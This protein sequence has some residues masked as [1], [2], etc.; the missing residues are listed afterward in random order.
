MNKRKTDPIDGTL[1]GVAEVSAMTGFT[2]HQI[3]SWR[4]PEN[5]DKAIFEAL[6]DPNSSTVWYRLV[7]VEDWREAH[8]KQSFMRAIPAPNAFKSTR[9]GT[10][11]EDYDKRIALE[12][13]ANITTSTVMAWREKLASQDSTLVRTYLKQYAEPIYAAELGEDWLNEALA[14]GNPIT[15]ANRYKQP[16]WFKGATKAMRM[17]V[18]ERSNYGFTEAEI[19]A[20]PVGEFPPLQEVNKI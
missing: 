13:V 15:Q 16:V 1:I 2:P 20:I 3:R 8:G 9:V 7:D 18:N 4:K 12:Q 19:D 17:L 11:I 5:Y 14:T 6:R 10:E